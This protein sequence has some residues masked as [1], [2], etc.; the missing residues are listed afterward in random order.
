MKFVN[1]RATAYSDNRPV[2]LVWNFQKPAYRTR[3]GGVFD[4]LRHWMR[5]ARSGSSLSIRMRKNGC[6]ILLRRREETS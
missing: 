5:E 2:A 6:R 3:C 4:L 1:P